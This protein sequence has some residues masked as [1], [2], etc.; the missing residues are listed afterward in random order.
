MLIIGIVSQ[1]GGVGKSTLARLIA[2]D[3]ADAGWNALI[4][5]L[6]IN[7]QTAVDWLAT[8]RYNEIEPDISVTP[9][10]NVAQA[11]KLAKCDVLILDG[12]P[13]SNAETKEIAKASHVV[14]LP[15]GVS[16]DDLYPTIRLAHELVKSKISPDKMLFVFGRVDDNLKELVEAR[17]SIRD[18]GYHSAKQ[19]LKNRTTYRQALNTGRSLSECDH[20]GLREDAEKLGIELA[21]FA[22]GFYT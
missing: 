14:L 15:T 1:K 8:R 21:K 11:L 19:A 3:F 4:A 6:D 10:K 5:D 18:A 13:T 20:K 12:K 16:T 22:N 17:E 7:Q 9:Y 2:R